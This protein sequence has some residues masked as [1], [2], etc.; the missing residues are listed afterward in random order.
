LAVCYCY[1]GLDEKSGHLNAHIWAL[2]FQNLRKYL[3]FLYKFSTQTI[4]TC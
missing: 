3:G 1:A 2:S 4:S